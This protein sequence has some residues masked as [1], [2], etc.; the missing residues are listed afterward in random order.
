MNAMSV[1]PVKPTINSGNHAVPATATNLTK[2]P[3]PSN[4]FNPINL[5]PEV[6]PVSSVNAAPAN[7]EN[8]VDLCS[9]PP[10]SNGIVSPAPETNSKE[11]SANVPQNHSAKSDTVEK[12]TIPP[13][14]LPKQNETV[15]E[16][17]NAEKPKSDEPK[18]TS[19]LKDNFGMRFI[20]FVICVI[21][22][23]NYCIV[24]CC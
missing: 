4:N 2:S 14:T 10:T 8:L 5:I 3:L 16:V 7:T 13:E 21:Y 17:K 23:Y 20:C 18:N 6:K 19:P 11:N 9:K 12:L 22:V 1:S 24:H 15:Q